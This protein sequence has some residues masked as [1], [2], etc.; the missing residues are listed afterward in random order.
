MSP[1]SV[2]E[3]VYVLIGLAIVV[4]AAGSSR[5]PD[6][7][8]PVGRLLEW[9]SGSRATRLMLVLFWWWI[10]WHFFVTPPALNA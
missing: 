1:R 7:V 3:W 4:L 6:L 10:A 2:T 8:A 5:R 9:L